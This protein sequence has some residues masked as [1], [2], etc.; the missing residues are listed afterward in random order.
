MS[1]EEELAQFKQDFIEGYVDKYLDRLLALRY[2]VKHANN[3]DEIHELMQKEQ[4]VIET[5]GFNLSKGKK[6]DETKNATEQK[7]QPSE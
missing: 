6:S 4:E 3:F 2:K 5:D 7:N 1:E